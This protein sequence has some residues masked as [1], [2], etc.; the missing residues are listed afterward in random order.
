M[1]P[2]TLVAVSC[3]SGEFRAVGCALLWF[4]SSRDKALIQFDF[5]SAFAHV[6]KDNPEHL[7]ADV[8][9]ADGTDIHAAKSMDDYG[10]REE[11]VR[12]GRSIH[13]NLLFG[14][15]QRI[16]GEAQAGSATWTSLG[17]R[18]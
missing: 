15:T 1:L 18:G 9:L 16:G 13:F 17:H 3:G 6:G 4:T 14:Q 12:R 10:N 7:D 11:E 5:L 2:D 8:R